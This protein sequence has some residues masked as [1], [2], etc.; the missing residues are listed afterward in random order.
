MEV[1]ITRVLEFDPTNRDFDS[2]PIQFISG[3]GILIPF[4]D[5]ILETRIGFLD[6]NGAISMEKSKGTASR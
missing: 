4:S 6:Q 5:L 1:A 2:N 3:R